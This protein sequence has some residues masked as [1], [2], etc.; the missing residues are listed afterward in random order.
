M[1]ARRYKSANVVHPRGGYQEPFDIAIPTFDHKYG[2]YVRPNRVVLKYFDF[3][4][5]VNLD[6]H[7]KVFNSAV[8]ENAKTS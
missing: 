6:A 8:K 3:K 1:V 7:I 2:H 5:N 4:K